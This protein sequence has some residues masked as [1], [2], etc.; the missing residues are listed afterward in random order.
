MRKESDVHGSGLGVFEDC[1][2]GSTLHKW[3]SHFHPPVCW[4]IELL[5]T[6]AEGKKTCCTA[7]VLDS[8]ICKQFWSMFWG[9]SSCSC[10]RCAACF[11]L[12]TNR[13]SCFLLLS[14]SLACFV[15][16]WPTALSLCVQSLGS[17]PHQTSD[18][19]DILWKGSCCT[20][21]LNFQRSVEGL[22]NHFHPTS[23]SLPHH[24]TQ[25]GWPTEPWNWYFGP[26]ALFPASQARHTD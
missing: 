9:F 17:C 20:V 15:Q 2:H 5:E 21:N 8:F 25:P 18:R 14:S 23:E 4:T 24:Y 1:M 19:Y 22:W 13:H 11:Q 3:M 12:F 6:I 16:S 7:W 26:F 10:E